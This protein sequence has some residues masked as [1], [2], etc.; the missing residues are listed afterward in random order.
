M[1][2]KQILNINCTQEWSHF[3][4]YVITFLQKG[5]HFCK[6]VYLFAQKSNVCY[7]SGTFYKAI[8]P[9]AGL[10]DACL[11]KILLCAS[12]KDI[13]SYSIQAQLQLK[14]T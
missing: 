5:I 6:K 4:N 12:W 13:R 7:M 9:T 11:S 14:H 10:G 2:L 1:F 8:T 3:H